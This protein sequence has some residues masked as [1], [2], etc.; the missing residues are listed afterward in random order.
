MLKGIFSE[1]IGRP[2]LARASSGRRTLSFVWLQ[3]W[4]Q[5]INKHG[6]NSVGVGWK[7]SFCRKSE[8]PMRSST[9]QL[10]LV[11]FVIHLG[12]VYLFSTCTWLDKFVLLT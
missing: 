10:L 12:G 3:T 7:D 1:K 9:Q 8:M 6:S 5:F 4:W 2:W 11:R